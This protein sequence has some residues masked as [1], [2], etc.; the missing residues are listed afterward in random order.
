M[1]P[2]VAPYEPLTTSHEHDSIT[3]TWQD[4]RFKVKSKVN[5]DDQ[6]FAEL[7]HG[8]NGVAEP[9][10]V[11]AIMGSS[12]A[13]KT[14]LLNILSDRLAKPK[15][16]KV[17]GTVLANNQPISSIDY[18][19]YVGYVMQDDIL[20]DTMTAR[21]CLTFSANL[22][23]KG[24]HDTRKARVEA[25]LEELKLTG[26]ADNRIGTVMKRGLSGGERR[27]VSIAVEMI[28]DP[29]VIFLDGI[30]YL[31]PT[32]GLDS[33][34]ALNVM[35]LLVSLSKRGIT[36]VSTIHQPSIELFSLFDKLILMVEGDNV[37]QG[38]P[39]Q[40]LDHF[41][42]LNF[43]PPPLISEPDFYMKILHIADRDHKTKE[44]IA[45]LSLFTSNY[46]RKYE[47][48]SGS[49]HFHALSTNDFTNKPSIFAEFKCLFH[50]AFHNMLRNFV[51][52]WMKIVQTFV[53]AILIVL[54]Y[55]GMGKGEEGVQDRG[56]VL[57]FCQICMVQGAILSVILA[58]PV[59]RALFLKEQSQSLYSVLPYF[60]GKVV[61][62]LPMYL[63]TP[64]VFGTIVYF[65]VGLN[66]VETSKFFIFSTFH[67]VLIMFLLHGIGQAIGLIVGALISQVSVA[68]N[69]GMI[70]VVPFMMF[71]GFFSST[72]SIPVAFRWFSYLSVVSKQPYRYGFEALCRNE[73]T[74]LHLTC[75]H[76]EIPEC[77]P[78]DPLKTFDFQE[79]MWEAIYILLGYMVA[80]IA[81]AFVV[82]RSKVQ[83]LGS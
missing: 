73:F 49:A 38:P 31:E 46:D 20:L 60:L 17:T 18:K 68:P 79:G 25:L 12:G 59:E 39:N 6:G 27:R 24:T 56:G 44:E 37:Y 13:G 16:T 81:L 3:L 83:K 50:R 5:P 63:F 26:V 32:S 75:A 74:H 42:S 2:K 15:N 62:E 21:E 67:T 58:F 78:C 76:C 10:Q 19:S 4:I 40:A 72:Q 61:S 28:V 69:A 35:N 77:V 80:A 53:Y 36:V 48:C 70:C 14:T 11:L 55:N 29:S 41:K 43:T 45:R 54:I 33:T 22:R 51:T 57:F 9:A 71:G 65:G 64:M 1:D 82:L 7:I 8:V 23:L 52:T 30:R 47:I 34:N 66:T